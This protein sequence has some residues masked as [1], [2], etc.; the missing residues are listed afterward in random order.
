V[1]TNARSCKH[2]RELLGEAYEEARVQRVQGGGAEKSKEESKKPTSRAA[3]KVKPGSKAVLS[4]GKAKVEPVEE[5]VEGEGEGEEDGEGDD[6]EGGA[7]PV[8]GGTYSS[9]SI[10]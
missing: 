7:E 5:E 1:E 8:D 2:I 10:Q 4:K 9:S 3:A 6:E